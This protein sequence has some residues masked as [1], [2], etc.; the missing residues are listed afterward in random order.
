MRLVTIFALTLWNPVLAAINYGSLEGAE[1]SPVES[2]KSKVHKTKKSKSHK[3]TSTTSHGSST[4]TSTTSSL[5]KSTSTLSS[6][7]TEKSITYAEDPLTTV[8]TTDELGKTTVKP[9]WW[10]PSQASV[11]SETDSKTYTTLLSTALAK[12]V[13]LN[14][15]TDSVSA[16]SNA[17]G[18]VAASIGIAGSMAMVLMNLI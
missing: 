10:I 9:L 16:Q 6:M 5:E 18:N 15:S 17:A 14:N 4:V 7:T 3:Q 2:V 11:D 1:E 8:T 13:K 12:Q